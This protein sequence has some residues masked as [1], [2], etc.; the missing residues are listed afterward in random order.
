MTE[1]CEISICPK[2]SKFGCS[3]TKNLKLCKDHMIEHLCKPGSR[4]H[5]QIDLRLTLK[6][7]KAIGENGLNKLDAQ[8]K[9]IQYQGKILLT[10]IMN[11]LDEIDEAIQV[12]EKEILKIIISNTGTANFKQDIEKFSNI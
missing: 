4:S 10:E 12:N 5:N 7:L 2:V 11:M 9:S 8:R 3:C 6:K 1:K